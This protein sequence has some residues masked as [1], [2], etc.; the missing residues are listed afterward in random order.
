MKILRWS[1]NF[2]GGAQFDFFKKYFLRGGTQLDRGRKKIEYGINHQI[3]LFLIP[4]KN[5]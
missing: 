5:G 4:I 3:F 1:N 2:F